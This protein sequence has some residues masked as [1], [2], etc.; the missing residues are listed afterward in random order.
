MWTAISGKPEV[1]INTGVI[2]I[3]STLPEA[4][5]QKTTKYAYANV[6]QPP[7]PID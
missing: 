6:L 3:N 4:C 7:I 1:D 2:L 5:L